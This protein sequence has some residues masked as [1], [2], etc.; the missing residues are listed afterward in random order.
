MITFKEFIVANNEKLV[1]VTGSANA[2]NQC[3]DLA[4]A[5]L[6][7]V[8]NHGIVKWTNAIDFPEKLTD[9]KWIEN[10][11]NNIPQRGDLMIFFGQY[12]HISIYIEGDVNSFK[13]FDQNYPTNSPAHIQ[14]HNYNN[15]FG[16]LRPPESKDMSREG[17]LSRDHYW[18]V[19]SKIAT[20]LNIKI[21]EEKHVDQLP[22][23]VEDLIGDV[24]RLEDK[25]GDQESPVIPKKKDKDG[26]VLLERIEESVKDEVKI[27]KKYG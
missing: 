22:G 18:N 27:I 2:L 16:W 8:L 25:L 1:E 4:N 26:L 17:E 6:R 5:Y 7:D 12:G 24:L 20:H 13:S 11:R 10:T 15:V 9:F 3:V 19:L 21:S 23:L 14:K